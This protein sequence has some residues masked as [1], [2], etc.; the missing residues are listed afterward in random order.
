MAARRRINGAAKKKRNPKHA[1]CQIVVPVS[2]IVI[3]TSSHRMHWIELT[4]RHVRNPGFESRLKEL[5]IE[6]E[7]GDMTQLFTE[8][9]F[10]LVLPYSLREA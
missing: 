8:G 4:H 6:F 3:Y 10:A 5:V 1:F 2:S 7:A 9:K